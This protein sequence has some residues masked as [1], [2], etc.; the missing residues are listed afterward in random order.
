[1]GGPNTCTRRVN[2]CQAGLQIIPGCSCMRCISLRG[3]CEPENIVLI[4]NEE[5]CTLTWTAKT[6]LHLTT[7]EKLSG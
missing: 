3:C 2:L 6:R 4:L 7:Y 5:E 1:M